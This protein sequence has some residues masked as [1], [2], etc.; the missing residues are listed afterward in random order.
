MCISEGND[1]KKQ[2]QNTVSLV[3]V[4]GLVNAG[5]SSRVTLKKKKK[6]KKNYT[7]KGIQIWFQ[8]IKCIFK[9]LHKFRLSFTY[10]SICNSK[11]DVHIMQPYFS[12]FYFVTFDYFCYLRT[13]LLCT[14]NLGN[15][16]VKIIVYFLLTSNYIQ[17]WMYIKTYYYYHYYYYY[18]II[19]CELYIRSWL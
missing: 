17:T 18:I 6:K 4:L 16:S 9:Q 2:H 1:T 12:R 5:F 15:L 14:F 3:L 8:F 10:L 7:L 19:Q 11:Y 13:H